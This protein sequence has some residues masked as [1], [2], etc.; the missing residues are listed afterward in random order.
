[1]PG[2]TSNTTPTTSAANARTGGCG[3][4]H[5]A[6]G[7]CAIHCSSGHVQ[8]TSCSGTASTHSPAGNH[9]DAT[10]APS[11]TVGHEQQRE[12]RNRD[13]I[14]E[15][16]QQRNAAERCEQQR[17]EPDRDRDLNA[18]ERCDRSVAPQSARDCQ[19]DDRD[20]AERQPR[21]RRERRKRID[22]QD[23]DERQA[24]RLRDRELASIPARAEID[25]EHQQRALRRHR[26]SGERR[27]HERCRDACDDLAM[28]RTPA[29]HLRGPKSHDRAAEP[30]GQRGDHADMQTRD[31]HQVR[32]PCRR[33]HAPLLRRH[34]LRV[35]DRETLQN[36]EN[37]R[38]AHRFANATGNPAARTRH[39]VAQQTR[40]AS[41]VLRSSSRT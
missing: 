29:A 12:Q 9:T 25:D 27:I 23:A 11:S 7:H 5:S 32:R 15:R 36:A 1:M 8:S 26:E 2:P 41:F 18:R 4:C 38:V 37:L 28:H 17:H 39:C 20:C 3:K 40:G 33:E 24:E 13:D 21:A 19:Q 30:R 22:Q 31:R 16:R 35:A 14:G 34:R 10:A 6:S